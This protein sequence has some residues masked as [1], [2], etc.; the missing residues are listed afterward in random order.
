VFRHLGHRQVGSWVWRKYTL[1]QRLVGQVD[2]YGGVHT[3]EF[4]CVRCSVSSHKR[5]KASSFV[6]NYLKRLDISVGIARFATIW[7]V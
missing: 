6:R 1:L 5:N 7:T 2:Y 3:S 4:S